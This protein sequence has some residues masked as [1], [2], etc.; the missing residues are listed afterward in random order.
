M[1]HCVARRFCSD[2]RKL[3]VC[4]PICVDDDDVGPSDRPLLRVWNV[5]GTMD[6]PVKAFRILRFEGGT[7]KGG[8]KRFPFVCLAN[9]D[10]L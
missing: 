8:G 1:I 6:N 2:T 3:C 9:V 7:T 10:L 5:P 4:L